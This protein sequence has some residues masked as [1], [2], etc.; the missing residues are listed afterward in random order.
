L[1]R[2]DGFLYASGMATSGPVIERFA[3]VAGVAPAAIDRMLRPLRTAGLV[4]MGE[5]GR[6]QRTGHYEAQHL[7]NVIMG[8]A[9]QQFTDATDAVRELRTL[10]YS[11]QVATQAA[12]DAGKKAPRPD[13]T[14]GERLD[15]ILTGMALGTPQPTLEIVL[16]VTPGYAKLSWDYGS[17]IS[18]FEV[19]RGQC[20]PGLATVITARLLAAAADLLADTL[21]RQGAAAATVAPDTKNVGLLAGRPTPARAARKQSVA[22]TARRLTRATGDDQPDP[23][24][25]ARGSPKT[26]SAS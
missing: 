14:F 24:G 6:G 7:A 20:L 25:S 16:S 21:N 13:I 22:S 4:P 2:I 17:E 10:K 3:E 15:Q 1:R 18:A 9:G 5:K 11:E 26:D 19:Y 12:M 23:K 8:F